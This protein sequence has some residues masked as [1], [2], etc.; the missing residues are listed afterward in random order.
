MAKAEWLKPDEVGPLLDMLG[1]NP[2]NADL[3][4]RFACSCCDRVWGLIDD[5]RSR[6]TLLVIEGFIDGTASLLELDEVREPSDDACW[7]AISDEWEAEAE[8]G[9]SYTA[10]YC[11][12]VAGLHAVCAVDNA[13]WTAFLS[14]YSA[15]LVGYCKA[16]ARAAEWAIQHSEM[17]AVFEYL[18]DHT[19]CSPAYEMALV[20]GKI[21]AEE[22]RGFQAEILRRF[23][24]REPN[25]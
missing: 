19:Y 6:R 16:A 8:A 22:E 24:D 10:R 15:R 7:Q 2:A 9:F 3:L 12:V 20:A 21:A 11:E 17:A 5:D 23:A 4:R 18:G 14:R 13:L 1:Q 25:C